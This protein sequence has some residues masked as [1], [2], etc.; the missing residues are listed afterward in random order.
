MQKKIKRKNNRVIKK[1]TAKLKEI[2]AEEKLLEERLK[3]I[4]KQ[5]IKLNDKTQHAKR[6]NQSIDARFKE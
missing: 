4:K 3:E 2:S 5:K 6:M 1:S